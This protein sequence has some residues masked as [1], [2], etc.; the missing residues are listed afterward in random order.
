MRRLPFLDGNID[1]SGWH[2]GHWNDHADQSRSHHRPA[3]SE[4]IDHRTRSLGVSLHLIDKPPKPAF[5]P[6]ECASA[7]IGERRRHG[8][9]V[10]NHYG[11]W[12]IDRDDAA[13]ARHPHFWNDKHLTAAQRTHDA[14]R[15]I[16]GFV[17]CYGPDRTSTFLE[18][19]SGSHVLWRR[20]QRFHGPHRSVGPRCGGGND[21]HDQ[22]ET[23]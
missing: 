8:E 3:G 20:H 18:C 6:V 4:L 19:G 10:T 16:K 2:R 17:R 12:L 13:I 22:G 11:A 14:T 1:Y 15:K 23:G 21:Y 9:T 5:G 7:A